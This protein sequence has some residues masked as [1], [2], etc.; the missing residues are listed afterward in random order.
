MHAVANGAAPVSPAVRARLA[1]TFAGC[2]FTDG[3]GSSESGIQGAARRMPDDD[4]STGT[5]AEGVAAFTVSDTTTV[6][7]RLGDK[8]RMD[9]RGW[10]DIAVPPAG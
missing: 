2:M 6:L 7:L 3:M 10:L 8:A 4:A 1:A 9:A 5:T